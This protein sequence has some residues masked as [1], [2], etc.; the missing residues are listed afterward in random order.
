[1][2]DFK[3]HIVIFLNHFTLFYSLY[4]VG[5][6]VIITNSISMQKYYRV[7]VTNLNLLNIH[8]SRENNK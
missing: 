1:M 8:N 7:T 4:L 5:F 6:Q 3:V 2:M